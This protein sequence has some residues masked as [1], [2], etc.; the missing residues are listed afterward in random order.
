VVSFAGLLRAHGPVDLPLLVLPGLA[1]H[2]Q[3]PAFQTQVLDVGGRWPP[4]PEARSGRAGRSGRARPPRRAR[5]R[6]GG[7]R[8]RCG[9]G[10]CAG[11]V[12]Q[13][14]PP[15]VRGRRGHAAGDGG[16]GPAAALEFPGDGLDVCAAD[17]EQRHGP[18]SAPA[19]ELAQVE[20]VRLTVT[21]TR[22]VESVAAAIMAPPGTAGTRE[23]GPSQVSAMNDARDVRSQRRAG[24]TTIGHRS[25]STAST[26]RSIPPSLSG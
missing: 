4:I 14:G 18:S 3:Q 21:G 19:G 23:A 12:V 7:R 1:K 13:P 26:A 17:R 5:R 24:Y 9:T 8:P 15:D 11:L 6:L 20:G 22:E 16:Q 10:R 2:G 25:R